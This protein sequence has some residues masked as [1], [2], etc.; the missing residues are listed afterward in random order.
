M[1]EVL[2]DYL[3]QIADMAQDLVKDI[4]E[5]KGPDAEVGT[6]ARLCKLLEFTNNAHHWLVQAQR[7]VLGKWQQPPK[8]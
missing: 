3:R 7:A 6:P 8:V 1:T 2:I 4:Q 5:N